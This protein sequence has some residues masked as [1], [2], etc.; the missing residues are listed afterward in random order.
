MARIA[1][2]LDFGKQVAELLHED[3][4]KVRSINLFAVHDDV[5]IITVERF[6]S[7]EEVEDLTDLLKQYVL[8]EKG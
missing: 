4:S 8:V 7:E 5:I 2:G 6:A 1:H 3:P